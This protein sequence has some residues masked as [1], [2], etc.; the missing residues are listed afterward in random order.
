MNGHLNWLN[1]FH[2]HHYSLRRPTYYSDI[3]QDF[4]VTIPRCYKDFYVNSFF[5]RTARLS[6]SVPIECLPLTGHLNGFNSR[7]KRNLLAVG[8]F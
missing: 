1:W 5:P 3:S 4:S 8:F 7:I 6:N 2:S